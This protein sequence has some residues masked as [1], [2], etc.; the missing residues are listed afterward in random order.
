VLQ[1]AELRQLRLQSVDRM[2]NMRKPAG[3]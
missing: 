2:R 1:G 3:I